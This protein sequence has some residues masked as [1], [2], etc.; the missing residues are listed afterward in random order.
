[1]F[2]IEKR[3]RKRTA[4][5]NDIRLIEKLREGDM[6]PTVAKDLASCLCKFFNI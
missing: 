2:I 4:L 5:S 6:H 3:I 1:M